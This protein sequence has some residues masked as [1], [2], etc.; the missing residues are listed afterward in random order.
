MKYWGNQIAGFL[1]FWGKKRSLFGNRQ[2]QGGL[3]T[4]ARM[5]ISGEKV[6][7]HFYGWFW[8][9]IYWRVIAS[10]QKLCNVMHQCQREK[11]FQLGL[12]VEHY[13]DAELGHVTQMLDRDTHFLIEGWMIRGWICFFRC[14]IIIPYR[15]CHSQNTGSIEPLVA[16]TRHFLLLFDQLN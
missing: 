13:T 1:I 16:E 7:L 9:V 3:V 11:K 12:N 2:H 10:N 4:T 6:I 15:N 14:F 5:G 8:L